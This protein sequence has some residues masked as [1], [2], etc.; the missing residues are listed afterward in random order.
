MTLLLDTPR[1]TRR[2]AIAHFGTLSNPSKMPC[3]GTS[4]PAKYCKVGTILR[5]VDGSTCA[6]CYAFERGTYTW[7]VVQH[8][9]E[10]RYQLLTAALESP[11]Q[12][13]LYIQAGV[14]L[15]SN[16]ARYQIRRGADAAYFR[17]L[18]SGDIVNADHL[19]IIAA[20]AK[21]TAHFPVYHW[22]PTRQY[23]DVRE[24]FKRG[25][26]KPDNLTIR[27][28]APMVDKAAPIINNLPTST[29]S[30]TGEYTCPA[31]TQDNKCLDCRA[32]W[33]KPDNVAYAAH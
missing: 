25:N 18:D 9:L 14:T 11:E 27:I 17:W 1:M 10:H 5:N 29:V 7:P 2:E 32:C 24:Y 28:S 19:E 22:L 15:I 21:Q 30:S 20:I 12:R 33:F 23:A 3:F 6:I 13:A 8:A 4:L 26:I 31:S 16:K